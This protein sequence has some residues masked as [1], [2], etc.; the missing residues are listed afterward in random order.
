MDV[1]E[2]FINNAKEK[3]DQEKL[4]KRNVRS[5][6]RVFLENVANK[7]CPECGQELKL[8]KADIKKQDN[9][10]QIAYEFECGHE[11]LDVCVS[12]NIK[13]WESYKAKSKKGENKPHYV[14][15][16]KTEPGK[17]PKYINGVSICWVADRENNL[18]VHI[19]KDLKTGK[20]L[21]EEHMP[22]SEHKK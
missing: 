4:G 13:I 15:L 5:D 10:E 19:I 7:K 2:K 21:H 12:E 17:N 6:Y 22:L 14:S 20:I 8:L 9:I 11:H 18:W 16:S 1:L 3:L